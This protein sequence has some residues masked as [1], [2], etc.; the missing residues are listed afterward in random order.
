MARRSNI[1]AGPNAM[2]N[3]QGLY[4]DIWSVQAQA[5]VAFKAFLTSFRDSFST[6][7]EAYTFIG[8]PQPYRKQKT[9]ERSVELAFDVPAYGFEEAQQNLK[10]INLLAKMLHPL[11]LEHKGQTI[12]V[13]GGDPMFKIRFLN[14]LVDSATG[15]DG[16]SPAHQSGVRGYIDGLSYEFV[17]DGEGGGF[18][19]DHNRA[20]EEPAIRTKFGQQG[21]SVWSKAQTAKKGF[22]YP[23]LMRV[24]F[25]FYPF[26]PKPLFWDLALPDAE[27]STAPTW[28][29]FSQK[30]FPYLI[31]EK[32]AQSHQGETSPLVEVDANVRARHDEIMK[33]GFSF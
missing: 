24:S 23:K 33:R 14:F 31:P 10:N 3:K 15:A 19:N 4:V 16:L 32:V 7:L 18:I 5:N 27:S 21:V 26:E 29:A 30:D 11:G 6:Q 25:T 1:N 9:V 28:P 17:L 20:M 2:A 12:I 13:P 8:H 22:M